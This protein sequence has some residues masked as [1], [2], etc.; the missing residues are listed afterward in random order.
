MSPSLMRNVI[1]TTN[2]NETPLFNIHK[3]TNY[4]TLEIYINV[5][6]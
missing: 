4:N 5:Y 2:C 1:K 6:K 3:Y